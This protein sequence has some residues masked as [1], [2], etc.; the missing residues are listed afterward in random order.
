MY[1]LLPQTYNELVE[2][3]SHRLYG[4]SGEAGM[5]VKGMWRGVDVDYKRSFNFPNRSQVEL[6]YLM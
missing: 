2:D 5:E 4:V 1:W 6:R 3:E